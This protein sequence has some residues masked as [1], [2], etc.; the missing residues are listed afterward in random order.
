LKFKHGPPALGSGVVMEKLYPIMLL[1]HLPK[2]IYT[3]Q[4]KMLQEIKDLILR[5][6]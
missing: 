4:I 1:L 2:G 3:L 6:L 5:I